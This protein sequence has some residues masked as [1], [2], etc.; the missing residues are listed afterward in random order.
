MLSLKAERR[1]TRSLR[2]RVALGVALPVFVA[3]ALLSV[4]LYARERQIL[5][6]QLEETAI[7]LGEVMRGS[8]R[9]AMLDRDDD[10]L[11]LMLNDI[12]NQQS[13]LRVAVINAAGQ[14]AL[15]DHPEDFTPPPDR[16]QPGC[17][18]CHRPTGILNRHSAVVHLP[19]Q[20]PVLRSS[21]LIPNDPECQACHPA[22]LRNLGVLIADFSLSE[23]EHNAAADLQLHLAFTG[24]MT[25]LVSL[26]VYILAHGMIVQRVERLTQP[27]RRFAAGDFSARVPLRRQEDDELGELAGA[28]NRMA[29]RLEQQTE[30]EQQTQNARRQAIID[31]RQRLAR[32][33]HDGLAQAFGY[34]NTKAAAVRLHLQAGK[35]DEAAGQ[36]RQ[37]EEAT[38]GVF[39]DLREAI[40][41]LKTAPDPERTLVQ[42]LGEYVQR[43]HD[44]SGVPTELR[45]TRGAENLSLPPESEMQLLR[46]V[47]EALTNVR[48]H[49]GAQAAWVHL[50]PNGGQNARITI[51]D[52]GRGFE[53]G[54]VE[55]DRQLHF[56]LS[57]MRDR[58]AAAGGSL[59]VESAPGAGTRVTVRL[60]LRPEE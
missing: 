13:V 46:I 16:S 10:E 4:W 54:A 37:L 15:T 48:K 2:F 52:D 21:I 26:G 32:E 60:P 53:P 30:L 47:Q 14:V 58:A 55:L 23:L 57:S 34:V 50:D 40:L 20:A 11:A 59:A 12:G 8:L 18:D 33:L 19:G 22:A 9:H 28:V 39:A 49:A 27:L 17:N 5:L 38:K 43:F 3:F 45:V 25:L 36:L 35:T 56:G 44:M 29:E 24:L 31:E 51:G 41:N 42:T 7:R 6:N 1:F